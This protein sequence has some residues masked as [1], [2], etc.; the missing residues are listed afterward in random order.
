M[1][2]E[3]Y[4]S[5]TWCCRL[6]QRVGG[7]AHEDTVGIFLGHMALRNCHL[8]RNSVGRI[9]G[10][11]SKNRGFI[12]R[13]NVL[14]LGSLLVRAEARSSKVCDLNYALSGAFSV[15]RGG[16][17]RFRRREQVH[18]RDLDVGF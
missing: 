9:E 10:E 18:M 16:H 2:L 17:Y 15:I 7:Q 5:R 6:E 12:P 3:I 11:D 13:V 8:E 14:K 4:V 1:E